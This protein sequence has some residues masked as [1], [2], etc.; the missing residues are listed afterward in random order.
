VPH[1]AIDS[2][3]DVVK[4]AAAAAG[5]AEASRYAPDAWDKAQQAMNAAN[6]EL[7]VQQARPAAFRSFTKAKQLLLQAW[8][9]F[10]QAKEAA[11]AA[12]NEA[13][14][15]EIPPRPTPAPAT[16][17]QVPPQGRVRQR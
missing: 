5:Q 10:D 16:L 6:A 11:I 17:K 8:M 14:R 7:Q 9:V 2:E 15:E 4:A 3:I 1:S 13:P 12:K